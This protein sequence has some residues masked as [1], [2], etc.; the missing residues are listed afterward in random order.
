M[1]FWD[2]SAIVPL[3]VSQQK[4]AAAASL[5]RQDPDMAVWWGTIVECHSA[6]ARVLRDRAI[7]RS[8]AARGI[9]RLSAI[10]A[11]WTEV[12]PSVGLR[13]AACRLLR[14]HPLHAADALQL[15]AALRLADET[16]DRMEMICF[17][18]R[19]ADAARLERVMVI[20]DQKG[21]RP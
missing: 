4:T 13:D 10:A 14:A 18:D 8:G 21:S 6:I 16:G 11:E 3:L 17:D 1:R 20:D 7:D 5:R 9:E 12:E 19:L 15:A 2:A